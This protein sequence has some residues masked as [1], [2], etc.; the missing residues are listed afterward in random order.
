MKTLVLGLGN[1]ILTDDGVGVWVAQAVRAAL[2]P[3]SPVEVDEVSV[4]GLRLME[5]VLGYRR[6][7][8]IDA[9]HPP[10]SLPGTIHRLTL[11][12]L[13][14]LSP[15]RHSASAHDTTLATALETARRMG[16]ALPEEFVIYAVEVENISDFGDQPTPAVSQAIART[17]Q[18]VLSELVTQGEKDDFTRTH[19]PVSIFGR[20]D[21]R[22]A[23]SAGEIC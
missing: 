11:D 12:D 23:D 21:R 19:P 20:S 8:L 2:P 7:I 9:L 18:A 1:P 16:L 3:G 17:T 4:G 14:R 13:N 6:V 10:L 15:T 22:G 5:R